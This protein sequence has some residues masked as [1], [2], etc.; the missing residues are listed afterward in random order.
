[1]FAYCESNP[2]IMQDSQGS[3]EISSL[4]VKDED[5]K[6][7]SFLCKTYAETKPYCVINYSQSNDTLDIMIN[8]DQYSSEL[9]RNTNYMFDEFRF[10]VDYAFNSAIILGASD[11]TTGMKAQLWGEC[12][13]HWVGYYAWD[14]MENGG[15]E[16]LIA[17]S[18]LRS[19]RFIPDN[20]FILNYLTDYAWEH[21]H[22]IDL[23]IKNG[24]VNDSRQ[25][26]NDLSKKI[27]NF[28]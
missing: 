25:W 12:L 14:I 7:R 13:V 19:Y 23:Q 6:E 21:C 1:M 2:I 15:I 26:I 27:G 20:R 16:N 17:N 22:V 18:Y 24:N 10:W 5:P 4:T 3:R 9:I 11:I 28:Y 8:L